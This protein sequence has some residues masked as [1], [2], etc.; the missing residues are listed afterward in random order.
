MTLLEL[1]TFKLSQRKKCSNN[2]FLHNYLDSWLG[3]KTKLIEDLQMIKSL[4]KW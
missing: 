2:D 4:L 1:I 3:N